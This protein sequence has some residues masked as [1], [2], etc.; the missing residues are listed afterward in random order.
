M[1]QVLA[2]R[3]GGA[4][5]VDIDGAS[6][7]L[8]LEVDLERTVPLAMAAGEI[9]VLDWSGLERDGR[10]DVVDRRVLQTLTLARYDGPLSEIEADFALADELATA[11]WT[12]DVTGQ[13]SGDTANATDPT[14]A[15]F[16]GFDDTGTWLVGLRCDT[17][18][19]PAPSFVGRVQ[20]RE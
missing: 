16:P 19:A 12:L 10:G 20:I 13:S 17:C 1:L 8:D 9:P 6:A 7:V 18:L 14:G 5:G 3:P 4:L 2:P 11:T 15:P